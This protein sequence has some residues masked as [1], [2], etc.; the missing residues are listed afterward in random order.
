MNRP[1]RDC[2]VGSSDE[3]N[4]GATPMMTPLASPFDS[5]RLWRIDL[6]AP[7]PPSLL[8]LLSAA[9]RARAERFVFVRDRLRYQAAHVGLRQLLATELSLANPATLEFAAGLHGKPMLPVSPDLHF[10]LSHSGR[11]AVVAVASTSVGV[12]VELLR[13]MPD[14]DALA[15]AHFSANEQRALRVH[16][17]GVDRERAFLRGWTRKE[18]CLKALG[19]GL[20]LDTR[21]IEVGIGTGQQDIAFA[22]HAGDACRLRLASTEFD[23]TALVAIALMHPPRAPGAMRR[24][25]SLEACA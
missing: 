9:E 17:P 5:C 7:M 6:D 21:E 16:P 18:A 3:A 19:A 11:F 13:P 23:D 14:A 2:W 25:S 1:A 24:A 10:N 15:V 8:G 12:D 20:T 4:D 22:P